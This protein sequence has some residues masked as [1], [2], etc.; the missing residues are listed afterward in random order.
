M[1][2]TP[3]HEVHKSLGGRMIDFGGWSLPVQYTGIVEE[4]LNVRE[5][6]GLFD[7]SHM[8]ELIVEG[9]G[10]QEYIQKMITNDI[11]GLKQGQIAYSPMCY[12]NGGV[13]DDLLVYKTGDA[14]FLIIVNAS[15]TDKDYKWMQENLSGNVN[16]QNLSDKYAQLAL[17]GPLSEVILQR[18]TDCPLSE[19]KFY[20]FKDK[21]NISGIEAIVS[22]TGY[23]GEDGFEVYID[24]SH[25][26]KM[27]YLVMQAGEDKGLVPAGLGARDTLRFEAALPLYGHEISADITPFEAGLNKFVKLDK[28][29]EFIG[30]NALKEQKEKGVERK[31]IGFQMV[32]RGLPRGGYEAFANSQK[33]G[34]VT[35]GGFSPSLKTN[36]G[37]ALVS[38]DYLK[39]G[40]EIEIN[41]RGKAVKAEIVKKPFYSKKYKK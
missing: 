4:H 10:A 6:A 38:S 23:T 41:I 20:N 40:T 18:L 9:P 15:N 7:V 29:M 39:T 26:E 19:I 32:D 2:K 13:V 25:A 11:S 34:F 27:W 24:P 17:Q 8:G 22:R 36:I 12:E 37:L 28:P 16:L 21:V 30:K 31:L 33:I 1:K 5:K 35:T 14:N 3:L